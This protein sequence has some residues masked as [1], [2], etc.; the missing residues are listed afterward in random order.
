MVLAILEAR[1]GLSFSTAEVYLNVSGGYKLSDPGADLAVAAALVSAFAE[2]PVSTDAVIFGELALSGEVRPIAHMN[3]RLK[4]SSK[5]SE[6]HKSELQS[7]MRISYAV[8]C[9]T[10]K[11]TKT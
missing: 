9:L 4:E 10:K 5:R 8:F 11:N 6:E 1:H 7:L 2:K 3:L